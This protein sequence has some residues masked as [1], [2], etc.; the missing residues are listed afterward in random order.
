MLY[1]LAKTT[2]QR[3]LVGYMTKTGKVFNPIFGGAF[4]MLCNVEWCM[5]NNQLY[6]LDS[7]EDSK[8]TSMIIDVVQ[9]ALEGKYNSFS[10]DEKEINN[11]A[12]CLELSLQN[13][14]LKI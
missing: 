9:K 13:K 6:A 11:I 14:L 7:L 3:A 5:K 4:N 10:F 8:T 1:R 12:M 2:N